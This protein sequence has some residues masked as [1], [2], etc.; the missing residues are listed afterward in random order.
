VPQLCTITSTH[1]RAVL[2][3]DWWFMGTL[4]TQSNESLYS[5]TVIG[6]LAVDGWAAWYIWY[7][8][9]GPGQ[10]AAL[11]NPLLAVP[12]VTAHPSTA[13]IPTSYYLMWH[14]NYLWTLKGQV[15][16]F[17]C[18]FFLDYC[19]F[20]CAQ[21]SFYMLLCILHYVLHATI[22]AIECHK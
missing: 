8:E 17:F 18:I 20:V 4:K 3:N 11:P 22:G 1:I 21:V 13:S 5:N 10:A 2:T 6:T 19:Q 7:N 16:V 14:Y 9:E 15:F 12:N